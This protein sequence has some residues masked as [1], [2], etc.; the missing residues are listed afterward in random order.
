MRW[1]HFIE[2]G[3]DAYSIT[4]HGMSNNMLCTLCIRSYEAPTKESEAMHMLVRIEYGTLALR[5]F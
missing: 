1:R 3:L 5:A 4:I 2:Q